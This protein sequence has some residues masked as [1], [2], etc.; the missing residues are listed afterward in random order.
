M[1]CHGL[2]E[3]HSTHGP[4]GTPKFEVEASLSSLKYIQIAVSKYTMVPRHFQTL[5]RRGACRCPLTWRNLQKGLA[6]QDHG[7]SQSAQ[8]HKVG[9]RR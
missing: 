2:S 1:G 7:T 3:T 6:G 5:N 8:T 4:M 9:P